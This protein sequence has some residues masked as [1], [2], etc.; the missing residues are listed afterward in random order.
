[1]AGAGV[2]FCVVVSET[3]VV[4]YALIYK[5]IFHM[6]YTQQ[7]PFC[8]TVYSKR[9]FERHFGKKVYFCPS[10]VHLTYKTL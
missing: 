1:M 6:L 7:Y 9:V 2:Y 4:K 8:I 10:K 5:N 3:P